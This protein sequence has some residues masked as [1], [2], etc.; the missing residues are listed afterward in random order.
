MVPPRLDASGRLLHHQAGNGAHFGLPQL[1]E[2]NLLIQAVR[3][4]EDG[5]LLRIIVY[6]A[7]EPGQA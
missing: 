5:R 2:N 4:G 7:M 6:H 3:G 1:L